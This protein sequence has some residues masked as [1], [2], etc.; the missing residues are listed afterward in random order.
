MQILCT[1]LAYALAIF[2]GLMIGSVLANR[3]WPKYDGELIIKETDEKI[4][5]ILRYDGDPY[6]LPDRTSVKLK[7]TKSI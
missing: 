4:V 6:D 1:I 5:W 7:I 3:V 2:G